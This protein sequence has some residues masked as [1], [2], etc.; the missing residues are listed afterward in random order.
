LRDGCII[1][2]RVPHA[3]IPEY[4]SVIDALALPR[5][6]LPVCNYISPLK[7]FEAMAMKKP[8]IAS[9]VAA[10]KEIVDASG[11]GFTFRA[12]DVEALTELLIEVSANRDGLA[13]KGLAGRH[14]VET[15]RNWT[16]IA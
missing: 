1:T 9:D 6:D 11:A 7:P 13:A 10:V 14:W 12:D 5:R 3:Q 16:A 8:L 15:V 4:Y 2:G